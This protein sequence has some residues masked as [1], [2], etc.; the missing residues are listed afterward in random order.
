MS[1]ERQRLATA[2]AHL[3]LKSAAALG[4][5]MTAALYAI[6][7]DR[8][9]KIYYGP[10]ED[11]YLQLLQ[12]FCERLQGHS[13]PFAVPQIYQHGSVEG[14]YF[15]IERRLP[16]RDLAHVFPRLG[17]GARQNALSS[18]VE[19]LKPLNAIERPEEPFGEQ[20][21]ASARVTAETWPRF[22]QKRIEETLAHSHPDLQEDLPGVDRVVEDFMRR[23]DT[24]DSEPPKRL[25]HGDFFFGNVLCDRR[26]TLTAVVDFSPLTVI[27]DPLMDVSAAYYFCGIYDFVNEEEFRYLRQKID[28]LYGP[29]SWER[30]DLYYTFYSFRFSDCK[31]SDNPTYRW[32]LRRLRTL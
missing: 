13:L 12:S 23:L 4:A 24:L 29:E 28:Q 9:L 15:Q 16:G 19:A 25:V 27:G 7:D 8:V 3:G 26:G 6:D 14:V 18:F 21:G 2:L 10:Q 22:L 11:A 30:I 1:G 32:C 20:L 17:P 5:G 31:V